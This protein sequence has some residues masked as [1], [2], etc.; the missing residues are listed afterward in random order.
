MEKDLSDRIIELQNEVNINML[1]A[2]SREYSLFTNVERIHL[3]ETGLFNEELFLYLLDR[4][5]N[6]IFSRI[7]GK[8]FVCARSFI[9]EIPLLNDNFVANYVELEKKKILKR[10]NSNRLNLLKDFDHFNI[11]HDGFKTS[12]ITNTLEAY[13][14][15]KGPNEIDGLVFSLHF[16]TLDSNQ[17]KLLLWAELCSAFRFHKLKKHHFIVDDIHIFSFED[18]TMIT[19]YD[20]RGMDI[21]M[22]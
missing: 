8:L 4:I 5:P 6:E 15:P 3:D 13:D 19:V 20:T 18:R 9:D 22:W 1:F 17:L 10:A 11:K 21:V 14:E 12:L 16:S 2:P 7:K